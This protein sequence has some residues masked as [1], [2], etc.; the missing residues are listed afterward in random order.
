MAEV[1]LGIRQ[2]QEPFSG[3]LAAEGDGVIQVPDD[4]QETQISA[5]SLKYKIYSFIPSALIQTHPIPPNSSFILQVSPA[6]F[7]SRPSHQNLLVQHVNLITPDI[8]LSHSHS[9][10]NHHLSLLSFSPNF[11]PSACQNIGLIF[12]STPTSRSYPFC[13]QIRQDKARER[14]STEETVLLFS[15]GAQP[16]LREETTGQV[17]FRSY[18][19]SLSPQ[20]PCYKDK[21]KRSIWKKKHF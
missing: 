4:P 8:K 16:K 21:R 14:Q 7:T 12:F 18:I 17:H 15:S 6:M 11:F 13:N 3:A 20:V 10:S 5:C 19:L 2:H 9:S 1:R